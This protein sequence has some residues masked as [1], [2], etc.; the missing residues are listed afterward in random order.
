MNFGKIGEVITHN[1]AVKLISIVIAIVLWL[2]VFGSRNDQ[3][4]ISV[5]IRV[6]THPDVAI[7]NRENEIPD[8]IQ[9]LLTGPKAFLRGVLD[10]PR[11]PIVVDLANSKPGLV[12]Y[13]FFSDNISL[14]IGVKVLSI[15]PTTIFIK[16]E[17]MKT[18][19]VP[20]RL[21]LQGK[22]PEGYQLVESGIEPDKV[23]IRGPQSRIASISE[24]FTESLSL[25]QTK[26]DIEQAAPLDLKR[27]SVEIEGDLPKIFLKVRPISANFR[28]KNVAIRV[29]SRFK[30]KLETP[31]VTVFVRA[32]D[33]DLEKLDQS[34]VYAEID[35]QDQEVGEFEV[36]IKVSL[37][38]T[39]GLVR[40]EPE[41]VKVTLSE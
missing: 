14:P 9:F 10:R 13:R 5:P 3:M 6:L 11:S 7:A 31:T 18:K 37:P 24:V 25:D 41:K 34:Q 39:L 35:L 2:L 20:V 16:L 1:F 15:E 36:P 26:H 4:Q 32:D 19:V 23:K 30:A 27:F 38:P 29:L 17:K 8:E 21:Q 28:I 12:T 40:V 22:P 33:K